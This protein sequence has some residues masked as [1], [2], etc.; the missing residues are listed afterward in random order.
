MDPALL[1]H[2]AIYV[3]GG[4]QHAADV[5]IDDEGNEVM[6]FGPGASDFA[7]MQPAGVPKCYRPVIRFFALVY[8]VV[9][10]V[11]GQ[12]LAAQGERMTAYV[13]GC[14]DR[15]EPYKLLP[16]ADRTP[17]QVANGEAHC[18]CPLKAQVVSGWLQRSKKQVTKSG[19]ASAQT[20]L[21]TADTWLWHLDEPLTA[22]QYERLTVYIIMVFNFCICGG[23]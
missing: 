13:A 11:G 20:P 1:L 12:D 4:L 14:G 10:D 23:T 5:E 16:Q 17:A 7:R 2:A 6:D 21:V 19:K 15:D 9:D 8:G 18:G 22:L 3:A